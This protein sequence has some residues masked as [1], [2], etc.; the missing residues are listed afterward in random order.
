[1]AILGSWE[2]V[3]LSANLQDPFPW[4]KYIH[5]FV[6]LSNFPLPFPL[7]SPLL[8]LTPGLALRW[9]LLVLRPLRWRLPL[10]LLVVGVVVFVTVVSWFAG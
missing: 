4:L 8:D 3:H 9:F 5:P 6:L 7:E 1:M 10:P 2:N